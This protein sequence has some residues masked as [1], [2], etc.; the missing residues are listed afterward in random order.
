[1]LRDTSIVFQRNLCFLEGSRI[2][3]QDML[4]HLCPAMEEY[5]LTLEK[6]EKIIKLHG[7]YINL[8][9]KVT[10]M[11]VFLLVLNIFNLASLFLH[12]FLVSLLFFISLPFSIFFFQNFIIILFITHL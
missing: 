1:M 8:W 2:T 12:D 9:V 7:L 4:N 10:H 3:E 5:S 6:E 11:E